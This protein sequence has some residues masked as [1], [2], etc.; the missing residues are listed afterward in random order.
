MD[1]KKLKAEKPAC[2]Q[3]MDIIRDLEQRTN[4]PFAKDCPADDDLKPLAQALRQI[5]D[6][7]LHDGSNVR[8]SIFSLEHSQDSDPNYA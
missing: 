7:P 1:G 3:I 4:R 5:Y 2:D 6:R 8:P